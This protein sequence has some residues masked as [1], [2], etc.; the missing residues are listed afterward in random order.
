MFKQIEKSGGFLSQ[1]KKGI[2]QKK[3]N[4]SAQKEQ[5][6]FDNKEIILL[7][8]NKLP[9]NEDRMKGDLQIY[10]FLKQNNSQKH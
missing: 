5:D 1:L 2:I 3:I 8:T 7:G 6:Q 4:D 10:P 9:N